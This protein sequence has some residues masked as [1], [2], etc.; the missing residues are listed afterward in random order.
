M[1]RSQQLADR[2]EQ[3]AAALVKLAESLTD[4]E[5]K[6]KLPHDGRSVGNSLEL[7][8]LPGRQQALQCDDVGNLRQR[9][10]T[11]R[12]RLRFRR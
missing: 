7:L 2:L 8:R 5:W 9:A 4:A 12:Q 6:T 1:P 10:E 11:L 3:G